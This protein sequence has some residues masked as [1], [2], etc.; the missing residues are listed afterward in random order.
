MEVFEALVACLR[1]GDDVSLVTVVR[2]QGSTPQKAGRH[3]LVFRDGS[4][5]GTIGGGTIE[6]TVIREAVAALEAG[7]PRLYSANLTRDLGMC[8]GGTM[9]VFIEPM[10][11]APPLILFGA[12]HVNEALCPMASAAGFAVTVVDEREELA[13][14]GRFPTATR[15]LCQDPVDALPTLDIHP[16]TW[17]LIVTHSHRLDEDL[18][19]LLAPRAWRYLGMIG[20]KAKVAKFVSR[21]E[22]RGITRADLDR[23]HMPVGL[24]LGAVTPAEIAV[25]ILAELIQLRR[26]GPGATTHPMS[27]MGAGTLKADGGLPGTP[28]PQ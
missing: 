27:L 22:A 16:D 26:R 5:V 6:H 13:T 18:L 20:S 28:A 7:A 25:S 4:I 2:A 14:P 19:R 15:V 24:N 17:L 8:C 9:E 1:R 3:M 23:V 21:L 10:T 12:G 11:A